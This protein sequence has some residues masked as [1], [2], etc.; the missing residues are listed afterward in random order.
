MLKSSESDTKNISLHLA[1]VNACLL[2][3]QVICLPYI[4]VCYGLYW[5]CTKIIIVN[6]FYFH[7]QCLKVRETGI[8]SNEWR[9]ICYDNATSFL[10]LSFSLSR[11]GI[12]LAENSTVQLFLLFLT[13]HVIAVWICLFYVMMMHFYCCWHWKMVKKSFHRM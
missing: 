12:L 8:R 1:V 2:V 4:Y 10:S 5:T 9:I 3:C 7:F 13:I 11:I 6:S